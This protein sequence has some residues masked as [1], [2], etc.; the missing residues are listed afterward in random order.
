[1]LKCKTHNGVKE[2]VS[3]FFE[4]KNRGGQ[5][6]YTKGHIQYGSADPELLI[7]EYTWNMLITYT[8]HAQAYCLP[9]D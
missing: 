4:H 3:L 2:E 6:N 5:Y 9:R 8:E 1:M 7:K